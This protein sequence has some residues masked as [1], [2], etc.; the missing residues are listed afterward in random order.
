MGWRRNNARA[1]WWCHELRKGRVFVS[2]CSCE[3]TVG[4]IQQNCCCCHAYSRTIRGCFVMLH[5]SCSFLN[6]LLMES[7]SECAVSVSKCLFNHS[8]YQA[9][10]FLS[11]NIQCSWFSR[12]WSQIQNQSR[13]Q[14]WY[15]HSLSCH[16]FSLSLPFRKEKS[17]P[18][19]FKFVWVF[20]Y[21]WIFFAFSFRT[22][23]SWSARRRFWSPPAKWSPS[24]WRPGTC[25]SLSLASEATSVS[26]TS[27]VSATESP[28]CASTAP[29]C[30]A[31][32]ARWVGRHPVCWCQIRCSGCINSQKPSYHIY[33]SVSQKCQCGIVTFNCK[34]KS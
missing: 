25:L 22:V 29:V 23:P 13:I 9:S 16:I 4:S 7:T 6:K 31:R 14:F 1:R 15:T 27:R 8:I 21:R 32:T 10:H 33:S 5:S 12:T 3:S 28:L 11:N 2:G 26:S 30:S 19:R 17:L 18:M 20:F 24:P 34:Q